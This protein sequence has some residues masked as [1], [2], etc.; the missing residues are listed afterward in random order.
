[1]IGT[2]LIEILGC[3]LAVGAVAFATATAGRLVGVLLTAV[4]SGLMA[5]LMPPVFS[6]RVESSAGI[7]ALVVNGVAGLLVAHTARPRR[8]PCRL[9]EPMQGCP[10]RATAPDGPLL[11][12]RILQVIGR[13]AVLRG[14]TSDVYVHVDQNSHLS[15]AVSELDRILLDVLRLALSHSNVRRVAVYSSRR[16]EEECIRVAAEYAIEPMFPRLRITGR[17]DDSCAALAPPGWPDTCSATWFDN[18]FELIYQVRMK[19]R[20]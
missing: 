16:P 2:H 11:A 7:A 17:T 19:R 8:V 18:G 20:S 10:A 6:L 3:F 9:A 14:R 5:F 15:I 1:M 13:D 12:E 4:A